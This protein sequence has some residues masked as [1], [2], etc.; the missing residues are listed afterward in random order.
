M[1]T[2]VGV[3]AIPVRSPLSGCLD[4]VSVVDGPVQEG[5]GDDLVREEGD[6]TPQGPDWW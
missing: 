4:L 5:L 1:G 2:C 3:G 6:T